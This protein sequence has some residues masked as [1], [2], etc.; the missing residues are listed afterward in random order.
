MFQI[1]KWV[2]VFSLC[3]SMLTFDLWYIAEFIYDHPTVLYD[4]LGISCMNFFVQMFVYYIIQKFK[5]H[6]APF[7]ITIRK[8]FSVI[9]SI[10]WFSHSI[11]SMQWIGVG[12]VFSAAL[13]DFISEKFFGKPHHPAPKDII[14]IL[15]MDDSAKDTSENAI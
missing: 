3:Y 15:P 6:I 4:I 13:F 9:I 14:P 12:V 10:F 2:F 5:Q 1:N 8:I 11:H 7:V